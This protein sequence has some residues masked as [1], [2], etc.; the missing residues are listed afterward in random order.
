MCALHWLLLSAVVKA[1]IYQTRFNGTTWD[2]EN[3][4]ITT[5]S[6]VQGQ[7]QERMS[8]ANGYLG[9][10]VAAVGPFFEVDTPVD[11]DNINGWPM[12]DRRQTFATIA[13]F[14]DSQ[15]LLNGTNFPW[16]NQ[17]GG[18][19]AISG[20]PHWSGLHLAVGGEVLDASVPSDEISGFSSTVDFAAGVMTWHYTWSPSNGPAIDVDYTM[21]VH[22]LYVNQA[23]VQL[24]VT[25]SRDVNASVIDVL[26]GDCAVRTTF[27]DKMYEPVLPMIWTAVS[28]NGVSNVTAYV[29]SAMVGDEYCDSGSRMNYTMS[30]VIGGNSSSIAQAMNVSL[31]AGQ[32]STITKYIGAASSDAFADPANTAINA[33]WQASHEGF[34]SMLE[35]Q[36]AEWASIMTDDSVDSYHLS[37]DTLPDDANILELQITAI[38]NAYHLL[39][40]TVGTNA[41]NAAGN[42][43]LLAV[44]SIAV[45]GLGSESY[46]GQIFWDAEVWM[47]PGLVVAH[48]DA[49]RQ[50]ALY[51]VEKFPQA[52]A[53]VRDAFTSSL[54]QTGRFS[55]DGAV[56]SWTSARYGNCT[57]VGPCFDYEYHINGD[58]GL[59]FYNYYAVTGDTSFFQSQLFPIYQAI[60]QFYIDILTLNQTTGKYQL[61]NGTDPDEYANF[62]TDIGYT[63]ALIQTHV[64]TANVLRQRFGMEPNMNWSSIASQI[65]IPIDYD[66]NLILEYAT[67]NNTISVKQADVILVDDFLDFPNPYSLSDL[68]YYAGKQ[69]LN[70]PGM[71]YGVFSIVANDVSPSGCSSYTYD[72]YGSQP[73]TRGPWFQFSEQLLDDFT[74]N[75]GTHPAY[76]FLTGHGG[77][78]RVAVFGYL[79]LRLMLDSFNVNP[80]LPPQIPQLAYR[81][82]YWQGWPIK[83]F[84]N[85]THT[86]LTRLPTPL[87]SANSTFAN[88]FIPVT[89]SLSGASL[90]GNTT[91]YQLQPNGTI[92]LTNRQIGNIQTVPGNIAQCQSVASP[93]DY[94]PGQFPLSAV[95]GAVSTKWQPT[96]SNISASLTVELPEPFVPITAINFDWAQQPPVSYSVTFSNSSDGSSGSVNVTSSSNITISSQYDAA[97]AYVI[98]PYMSNS[99]NV[100]LASPVY[101]GRYATLTIMGNQG[102]AGTPNELNGTGASV[103]EFAVIAAS[104]QNMMKRAVRAWVA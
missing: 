45:G 104:G 91:V 47:A 38:T 15:P 5:T 60:A 36:I 46:A 22:K 81:Q 74:A 56:Y 95:D 51:R 28:P 30:S 49:A 12:F 93:Q 52:Q 67:Q 9:I 3:W 64:N 4:R 50:I 11:G 83:A 25:A 27:V 23:A 87:A 65:N 61:L 71:T 54:N 19:S 76:P 88:S 8:L 42:N 40:Q 84:S 44:N 99:T 48:P 85:Q 78:H 31:I 90:S 2:D 55:P 10:N 33:T 80:S 89:V 62:Q 16:L 57:G 43:T 73:Y 97:T 1:A 59:E 53:N 86:T 39:Q 35:S 70:G 58:I 94:E 79:G 102:N 72:L 13:G 98:V 82:I 101:S 26:D 75:G 7:Y 92:T 63:M 37:N 68:D 32:T 6:L 29:V 20:I 18:E 34:T 66:A 103:A 100:T 41:I 17:Y 77:A 14:Y 24:K 21:L 69:S 96:Q